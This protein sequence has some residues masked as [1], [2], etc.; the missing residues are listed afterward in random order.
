MHRQIFPF[1]HAAVRQR[2]FKWFPVCMLAALI[3]LAAK[4]IAANSGCGK[5]VVS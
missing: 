2:H 5:A 1:V 3:N 4:R